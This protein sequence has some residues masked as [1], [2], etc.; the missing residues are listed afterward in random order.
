MSLK[1]Y[2][3]SC[4]C[5]AVQFEAD[6]DLS[7]G[8]IR[9]NCSYCA[10]TR[11]WF[12][13]VAPEHFR[14]E[15]GADAQIEY[16]WTPPGQEH[17]NLHHTFCRICGNSTPSRGEQGGPGGE[18]FHLIPVALLERADPDELAASIR[19]IDGRHGRFEDPPDDTRL[20]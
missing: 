7:E 6:V 14:L 13:L 2:H 9:C 5:G 11:A 3:G 1:T 20:M 8:T 15:W 19:F 18:P 12:T 10:K 17:P 16:V 4:H